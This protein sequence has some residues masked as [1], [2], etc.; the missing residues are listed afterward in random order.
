[1]CTSFSTRNRMPSSKIVRE[2]PA[3][4]AA[5]VRSMTG[6]ALVR[7]RTSAGELTVALRSVNHRGLD[8]HFHHASDLAP[9][10]NAMRDLLKRHIDRGHIEIRLSLHREETA[11]ASGCNSQLLKQYVALFRQLATELGLDAKPDLNTFFALPGVLD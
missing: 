1:V 6:Y 10:E 2:K 11:A 3:R 7:N 8:L 9:F 4:A 5:P